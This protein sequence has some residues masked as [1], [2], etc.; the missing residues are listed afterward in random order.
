MRFHYQESGPSGKP[1]IRI[2]F[3]DAE[4]AVRAGVTD[5][6][7]YSDD[8][9]TPRRD[10]VERA[11]RRLE[12]PGGV[13]LGLG[14]TRPFATLPDGDPLCWLQVTNLHFEKNPGWELG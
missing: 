1:A 9:L 13:I 11:A 3:Q 6:R 10:L 14:L 5:I 12:Q 7:F 4:L 2:T 8:H